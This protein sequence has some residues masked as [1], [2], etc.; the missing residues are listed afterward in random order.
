MDSNRV[1]G[2]VLEAPPIAVQRFFMTVSNDLESSTLSR[3]LSPRDWLLA[4]HFPERVK[5]LAMEL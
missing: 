5:L 3:L 1:Y 2:I 4:D